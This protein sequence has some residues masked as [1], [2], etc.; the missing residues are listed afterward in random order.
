M[1]KLVDDAAEAMWISALAMRIE[2]RGC[3]I[4]RPIA[5]RDGRWIVDGWSVW[6]RVAGEHSNTRWPELL[7]AAA[8][9]HTCVADVAKPEFIDRR[10]D[11]WRI[12]DRVA[13]GELPAEDFARIPHLDRLLAMRRPLD[14]PSQLIHGD[15][16]GN[17]LFE[18]GLPPA[19]IDLSLYWRPAGYSAALVVGDALAWEGADESIVEL[20]G[21]TPEWEQLLLRAVAFRIVVNDLAQQAEPWRT[22]VTEHYRP[23]ADLAASL[24]SAAAG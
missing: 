15:L 21:H 3:R 7:A 22:D 2:P 12:A 8:A 9:F 24:A 19:L 23:P 5:A 10:S 14:L 17:V 11:R 20:L 16:V 18:D 13:W 4:A 6:T 1:L